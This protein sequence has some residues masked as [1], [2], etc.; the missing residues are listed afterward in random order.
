MSKVR[1][2][3][4]LSD[5]GGHDR[6]FR[7]TSAFWWL[8]TRFGAYAELGLYWFLREYYG[9]SAVRL[10]RP[11]QLRAGVAVETDWLMVGLP[12]HVDREHLTNTRFRRLVLYDA[13]DYDG[14]NFA[15]SDRDFLL[16][17][18]NLCLK[19]WRD[20]RW[21]FDFH[22]GLLPIK[23]PPVNKLQIALH[24]E[25]ALAR[26]RFG[27]R[28]AKPFDVGFVARP[29]GDL[30][31]NPRVLWLLDLRRRRPDL[32][33]WGG[34]VGGGRWQDKVRDI[35][36]AELLASLW[37]NRRKIGYFE[38]F[39]G[40]A[41][42]K[43]AL[44]PRGFAPWTYRHYEAVYARSLVVSNDLQNYEMLVPLP[45]RGMI[46][47]AESESVVPAVEQALTLYEHSPELADENVDELE[48]W[49]DG[50]AYSRR[51][52]DLLDRFHEQLR[53]A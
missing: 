33:L 21:Q 48:R 31:R 22:I 53:A 16:S 2:T 23:R 52:P 26:F 40:L 46:Q 6:G 17:E 5:D 29:T 9:S 19:N 7:G 34:L 51:R 39:A 18:S 27:K 42:S 30:K 25:A 35:E 15:Y 43:V 38:Y 45:E 28:R 44:A 8:A 36:H 41:Q 50:G 3:V 4:V 14:V 12:T 32:K 1:F 47:V 37:L 11:S 13:T 24:R 20:R 10:L 49:L